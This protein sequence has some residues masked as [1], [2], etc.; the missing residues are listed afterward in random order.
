MD[1][2]VAAGGTLIRR[3]ALALTPAGAGIEA[4][5]TAGSVPP[6]SG[7]PC[8]HGSTTAHVLIVVRRP[9]AAPPPPGGFVGSDLL[10]R[11]THQCPPAGS[12]VPVR[13]RRPHRYQELERRA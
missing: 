6:L 3:Y 9:A 4:A 1:M 13:R 5:V 11:D 10:R 12:G 8:S 7:G 2:R